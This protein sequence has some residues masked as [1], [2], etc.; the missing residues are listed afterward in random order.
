MARRVRVAFLALLSIPLA[1]MPAAAQPQSQAT[2]VDRLYI[3]DCGQG[4]APDESRWTVGLNAGKPIDISVN[5][6]LVHHAQGYFL[7]D[8][9]HLRSGGFHAGRLVSR[10]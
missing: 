4:H 9:G 10:E 6:Y 8:T 7:W 1:L 2:G 3:L 5:C